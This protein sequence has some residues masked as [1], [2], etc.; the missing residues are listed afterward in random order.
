MN[1]LILWLEKIKLKDKN[2]VGGKNASLGEMLFYL[3]EQNILIPNGFVLTKNAFEQ[4]FS[5]NNLFIEIDKLF[6]NYK[7]NN[8]D[9]LFLKSKEIEKK[10]IDSSFPIYLIDQI[11]ISIKK[12]EEENFIKNISFAIRS[13]SNDEDSENNS[14]AGQQNSYLNIYE[15][16]NILDSIKKVYASLYSPQSL[17]YRLKNNISITQAFMAVCIQKMICANNSVSG[18]IFTAEPESGNT[19]IISLSSNYGLGESI[20]GGLSNPDEFL[21]HKETLSIIQKNIGSK[22]NK[23]IYADHSTTNIETTTIE[24]NQFTLSDEEIIKLSE[25]A[26]IIEKHF[27]LPVDIEFVKEDI[28]NKFFILQ[29]RPITTLYKDNNNYTE[30]SLK[31]KSKIITSGKAIG[32]KASFGKVCIINTIDQINTINKGDILVT[33]MTDPRWEPIMKIASAIVTNLGGRTCH[34]AIIARELGIP[35]IVGCN[36]ATQK[37]NTGQK[38]TVSCCEGDIGFIYDDY[39]EITQTKIDNKN[40]FKNKNINIMLN[41]GNPS[42]AFDFANLPNDGVGLARIEFIINNHIGIHPLAIHNFTNLSKDLQKIILEKINGYKSPKDFFISKLAEGIAT[43]AAA[44]YPKKVIIRLSD[45]KTNEYRNLIGGNDFEMHEEN[46]MIGFRGAMRYLSKYFYDAFIM[47]IN[48]LKKV[49]YD[50]KL[51][52]VSLL[53]PFVRTISE[54]KSVIELLKNHQLIRSEILKIYMMCEIPSNALLADQFLEH[55]DG[56][57]IGSNDMTQLILGIDRDGGKLV[58][59]NFDERNDAVKAALKLA[60]DA[61]KKQNKYIGICG[62][63]PS[64]YIDFAQWLI[65]QGIDSIS[66]LPDTV[67]QFHNYIYKNEIL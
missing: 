16:N 29:A 13:S 51:N 49:I 59:Q 42:L 30:Y 34:A 3:K 21:I 67:I 14:F 39:L 32:K 17:S 26:I 28:T 48:A 9:E 4:F 7:Y 64:D 45:F 58:T 5:Y 61:C 60:I 20:V 10:I 22:K 37:L 56:F 50:M 2:L 54:A 8:I 57:S 52:N 6:N 62:Q 11:K 23:S 38:I 66:L 63:G 15:I 31:K 1:N 12:L 47:E 25:Y 18:I 19:N 36:D 65:D 41:I 53:V 44:F 35:A 33:N 43:I 46:P 55:F 24:Q 40:Y 27:K